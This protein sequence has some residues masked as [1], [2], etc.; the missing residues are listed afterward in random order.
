MPIF[1]G[2]FYFKMQ[3]L[4]AH[5]GYT[6]KANCTL[7]TPVLPTLT[8]EKLDPNIDTYTNFGDKTINNVVSKSVLSYLFYQTLFS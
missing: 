2:L 6:S 1:R 8:D 4:R 7:F 5:I 3:N